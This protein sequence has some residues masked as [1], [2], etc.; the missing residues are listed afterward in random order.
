MVK[1]HA[2]KLPLNYWIQLQ[3]GVDKV[4]AKSRDEGTNKN[5]EG[6]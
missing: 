3:F 5:D 1:S 4:A 6:F 2:Q